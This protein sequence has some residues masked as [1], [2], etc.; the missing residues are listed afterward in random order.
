M[1]SKI[2]IS[3]CA[4]ALAI[5]FASAYA[6]DA[7]TKE[8]IIVKGKRLNRISNGATGLPMAIKDT[9]QTISVISKEQIS[10][11]ATSGSNEALA[12]GTGLNVAQYETNRAAYNARGFDVQLTQ[13]DGIGMTNDWGSVTGQQDTF[14]F[15]KIELIRGA[16][17]LLTGV[18]NA[19]GTINYVRKRPK[20]IAGGEFN[21]TA[22]DNSLIRANVDYNKV[23][24]ADG[25]WSGR[26]VAAIEDKDSYLRAL[27]DKRQV[28]YGVIDGQIGD[29]GVLTIG[30]TYQKNNQDSPMWGALGLIRTDGTQADFDVSSSTSQDWT[31]WNTDSI[32]AFAEYAYRL[33]D[34]WEAKV[35]YNYRK[36]NEDAKI[37]YAFG[38][39]NADNTGLLGW[40]YYGITETKNHLF[41]ASVNGKFS[42]FNREHSLIAGISHSSQEFETDLLPFDSSYLYLPFP[43]FPYAGNVYPEPVWGARTPS[44]GG[45]QK[46]TR[47]Y[48]ATRLELSDKVKVIIGA[49]AVNLEREGSSR[50]GSAVD[51]IKYPA[52]KKF[53][54]Y[55]GLTYD[56]TNNVLAYISYSDIFQN[57]DQSDQNKHYLDP[58]KGVNYEAGLKAEWLDKKLLT[59]L[60]I[61]E[62]EQEGLATYGGISGDGTYW[63][64]GADVTSKGF[65]LEATGRVTDN[66]SITVG[67]TNL[68]LIGPDGGNIYTW[69]PRQTFNLMVNTRPTF[70]PKLK[71]GLN[72]KWSSKATNP[73]VASQD[74]YFVL[75]GFASY[76]VNEHVV[77]K[78]NVNNMFDEK[79]LKTVQYSA[80]YAAPRNVSVTFGYKF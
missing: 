3:V 7:N 34:N 17:G 68:D 10:D 22:G 31:F 4:L 74:S 73:G 71:L 63:Y 46:L 25:R 2:L 64:Y 8:V 42:L 27:H 78:L 62:A 54:P 72:G 52:T 55:F 57:Q 29:S 45:E 38:A 1:R 43:A 32:T 20:N 12:M 61:F 41:D 19:S 79:Y 11:Y 59:T 56:I 77:L 21:I 47:A 37:L 60:A 24:T 50:Y 23:L 13:I 67:Y 51:V 40:P 5:P 80:Y 69:I 70:N 53:S 15:E 48:F 35:S 66:T 39:L 36:G 65:E 26:I 28:V 75:N 58:T 49:N 30:T 16:N 76:D 44:S 9:P 14:L 6:Q 33:S 18:G